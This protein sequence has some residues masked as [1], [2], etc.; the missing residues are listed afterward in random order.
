MRRL[1]PL[2]RRDEAISYIREEMSPVGEINP[3]NSSVRRYVDILRGEVVKRP[4]KP[5]RVIL[6]RRHYPMTS[7][8]DLR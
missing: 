1:G 4:P 5:V 3:R 6:R 2:Y 7:R 8:S